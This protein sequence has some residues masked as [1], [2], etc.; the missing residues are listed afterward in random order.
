[1]DA[2]L[3]AVHNSLNDNL[4][5]VNDV[6]FNDKN[7]TFITDST[8]NS[9][10]FSS[11]Q[12]QFDLSTLNSQSQ[13]VNLSEA[14]IEFPVKITSQVT[15]PIVTGSITKPAA[16][17]ASTIIKNGWHQWID[18]AQLIING[19]TI[20]SSQPYENVAASFRIISKW[21][22]DTLTKM[23]STCGVALDD[24]TGSF[25]ATTIS[26]ATGIGNSLYSTV[27][28][29]VKG[30]DVI[31]NQTS[32]LNKGIVARNN[33]TNYDINPYSSAEGGITAA[34]NVQTTILGAAAMKQSGKP[35]V[36]IVSALG[37]NTAAAYLHC[38]YYMATCRL[39]DLMDI[40]DYPLQK[41]LKGF[42]YLS[43]NSSQVVL[44]GTLSAGPLVTATLAS[45]AITPL[46]GRTTPFLINN[47]ATG[48][49][50]GSSSSGTV[51]AVVTV[52]GSVDATTTGIPTSGSCG[53]LLTNARLICPYYIANPRT[54][55]ALSQTTKFFT[56][57][58][59][60]V[61]PITAS[62]SATINY[63]ITTGVPN[64]R[65]L[66]ILPMWQ[67][68][69]GVTNLTNPEISPFDSVPATSGPFAQLNNF[70]VYVANKPIYQYPIQYDFEQWNSENSQLGL[71]GNAIS[72]QTSGLLS[73]QLFEQN[74]RY[75][76]VDLSRRIDSEDGASKSI[77]VT[78]TN[79]S[80]SFGMKAIAI[81]FYE[82]R[83]IMNTQ[84][85]AIMSV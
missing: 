53:P 71:N 21:G 57:L 8:S 65:K 81:V 78:F 13:W 11:G 76:Y 85:G 59:K 27:A 35:N 74:H 67:N 49:T 18:S 80:S 51:A 31:N 28:A 61:N 84:T 9:G 37:S 16:Q 39:K 1:M 45:V 41:N 77:Q 26:N 14:M 56:T 5:E 20:Q 2:D 62:A 33:M 50:L 52:V 15:T 36:S 25:G 38:A 10:S 4:S 66:V 73:Q 60:I 17:A 6:P 19:Q 69:G 30:L 29:N 55:S 7:Y 43:F 44:T 32:L 24:C 3:I 46:T 79:P 64:P 70:Q 42:L 40:D 23:G 58:E 54:D 63:T 34:P 75:Y 22:Q 48:I 47:S 72:E 12:I 82:K 68:L 83:W